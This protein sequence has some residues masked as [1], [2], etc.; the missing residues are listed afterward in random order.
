MYGDAGAF[1]FYPT[2]NLGAFGDGGMITARDSGVLRK[3]RTLRQGGHL[4]AMQ[5][6]ETGMNSRLDEL[7]AAILR[8]KLKHLNSW[9]QQRRRIAGDYNRGL[10]GLPALQLPESSDSL[11]HVFHVYVV[12]YPKRDKL[13]AYLA[14]NGIETMVHYPFLLHQQA[15]FSQPQQAPLPV[16]ERIQ[17]TVLSLPLNPWMR[18]EGISYVIDVMSKAPFV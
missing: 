18:S 6:R 10:G 7:Q 1:S 12:S 15:R 13:R 8:V 2:K 4:D 16:A 17:S 14:E 9:N 5:G 3:A 11:S